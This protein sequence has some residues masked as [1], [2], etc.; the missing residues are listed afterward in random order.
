MVARGRPP[1]LGR[2]DSGGRTIYPSD[3]EALLLHRAAEVCGD[4]IHAVSAGAPRFVMAQ[5]HGPK[6]EPQSAVRGDAGGPELGGVPACQLKR[7]L[8]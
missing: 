2:P 3:N 4:E 1:S 5:P 8:L 6:L 7:N